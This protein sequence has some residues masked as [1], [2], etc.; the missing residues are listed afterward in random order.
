MPKSEPDEPRF[1]RAFA[2][3]F[4]VVAVSLI[5][6]GLWLWLPQLDDTSTAN[7]DLGLALLSGGLAVA[8]GALVSY[9][10]YSAERRV[11]AKLRAS[12]EAQQRTSLQLALAN[13]RSLR[14]VN[15]EGHDL[16]GYD[17]RN[18]DLSHARLRGAILRGADLSGSDLSSANFQGADLSEAILERT[19]LV[20]TDF[21]KA[22]FDEANLDGAVIH[23][24]RTKPGDKPGDPDTIQDAGPMFEDATG[25]DQKYITLFGVRDVS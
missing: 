6:G 16:S 15:L 3:L 5:G 17:L 23:F 11:N 2:G 10:V 22:I 24:L 13:A 9:V 20:E 18:Q 25:L 7:S 4:V 21:T 14:G 12:N 1:P 19:T 8:T